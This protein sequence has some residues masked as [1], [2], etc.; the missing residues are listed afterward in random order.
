[1]HQDLNRRRLKAEI[2]DQS[3]AYIYSRFVG[4]IYLPPENERM[5]P[6]KGSVQ[7]E[8]N[9]LPTINFQGIC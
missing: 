7:N 4:G 1:M 2:G 5:S 9:H 8:M 3:I 6:E